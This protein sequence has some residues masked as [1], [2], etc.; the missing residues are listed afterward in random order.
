MASSLLMLSTQAISKA[1]VEINWEKPEKY[2]DVKSTAIP[3]SKFRE[4]TF[5]QLQTYLEKLA[6]RL[7]SD[8][9]LL[10]NVTNLDL[11][12]QVWPASFVGLGISG[13]DIRVVK[14]ID[15]P[16]M[17]FTYK[18]EKNS[19]ELVQ[20]GDVELKDMS[21]MDRPNRFFSSESLRYEKNML[22][23]WFEDE[24]PELTAKN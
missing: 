4:Q 22:K 1:E 6:E 19:G 13:S 18:L 14:S 12:G 21:F 23:N 24:F 15:I 17:T 16:R 8:Q 5:A 9:K 11:A 7:P 10:L 20:E 2:R 3:R